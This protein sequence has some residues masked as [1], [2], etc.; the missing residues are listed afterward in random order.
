MNKNY[1]T[2]L[3]SLCIANQ[4]A[5]NVIYRMGYGSE[6]AIEAILNDADKMAVVL[7][8]VTRVKMP[9]IERIVE[10]VASACGAERLAN[11]DDVAT[12]TITN[13]TAQRGNR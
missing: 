5:C 2:A 9:D 1:T 12:I 8:N 4:S 13:F 7:R 6:P 3:R 10:N 11:Y